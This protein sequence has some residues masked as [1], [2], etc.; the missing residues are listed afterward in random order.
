VCQSAAQWIAIT[1]TQQAES[2]DAPNPG[3]AQVRSGETPYVHVV[4]RAV[5][6]GYLC[7]KDK[8][9]DE[10]IDHRRLWLEDE[11]LRLAGIFALD[12]CA[13]AVISNHDRKLEML[14]QAWTGIPN[15]GE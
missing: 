3:Y 11:V 2:T 4:I 14:K 5:R 1:A 6:R 12:V 10:S 9:S 13:Y 15:P 8:F 7:S